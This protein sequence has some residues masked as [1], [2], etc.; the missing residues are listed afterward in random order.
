MNPATEWWQKSVFYEVYPKSFRDT[1]GDGVGDLNG[2]RE[3][4]PYIKSLGIDAIWL[5][6]VFV[7]P[8]FD[9]GYDIADY[10]HIDPLYG[11]DDDMIN[12]IKET[13]SYGMKLVM[14]LVVNH[15]S[16]QHH[17]FQ[18]SKKSQDNP[19]SDFYI[20]R[21]P[22]PDGSAPNNWGSNF[23]GSAW[24]Y[25][26]E[27]QQYY[28]HYFAPQQPDLNWENP[29]VR[30]A[31]YD[32]MRYWIA[33]GVDG[34]RM[35][36]ITLISKDQQFADYPNPKHQTFVV[37]KQ[38]DGPRMHE[39]IRDVNQEVLAPF[40][41]MS[42]GESP[43]EIDVH[44]L[45]DSDR[46]ELNMVFTFD[47]MLIDAKKHSPYGKWDFD[48]FSPAKLVRTLTQW[49]EKLRVH[50]WN[51]LYLENHDQ[52]RIPS[53]WGN[54]G[55]YRFESATAFATA[56]HGLKGTPFV[57]QG[58]EI[59]MTNIELPLNQYED[60]ETIGMV[61]KL[62]DQEH[63]FTADQFN[64]IVGTIGRDHARTPMQWNNTTNAGFT[65]G[66]PWFFVNPRY[67]EINVEAEQGR[68]K[69]VWTYY[70]HLI[71]LRHHD[72]TIQSGDFEA[73]S[74]ADDNVMM[75]FRKL[76]GHRLLVVANL[77]EKTCSLS[78]L[79]SEATVNASDFLISNYTDRQDLTRELRPYEAFIVDVASDV[80][81]WA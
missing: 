58:E 80:R 43:G 31:V 21:D 26:P 41:Q 77:S 53:R 16:D 3:K 5:A 69:S 29:A 23:G 22:K 45:I 4:L 33:R 64:R 75:Y 67:Q 70:Q 60:V 37:G 46:H 40:D 54:D 20:W 10:R 17:W 63:V 56:L 2:V 1:N 57:Y 12:L 65:S 68:A 51:A 47:H 9:N 19:Y 32:L 27:R 73:V 30:E 71:G 11:S 39:F 6:P 76:A 81:I 38:D 78:P 13:H 28:L 66:K 72:E 15:T 8:Q 36:V 55:Q 79:N 49:Q 61:K 25:V 44:E 14:D 34:W 35:D 52:A 74:D 62:V 59:G 18:E 42:V 7:S 50:G 48:G 24:T